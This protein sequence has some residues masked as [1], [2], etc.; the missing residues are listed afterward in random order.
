MKD[1]KLLRHHPMVVA[2]IIFYQR[3]EH[4]KHEDCNKCGFPH[5]GHML[6]GGGATFGELK[7]GKDSYY[8]D[9]SNV[10]YFI[11]FR[12]QI[13]ADGAFHWRD[14]TFFSRTA[15][16]KVKVTFYTR[17]NNSPQK[18]AWN[19]PDAEWKSIVE[20]LGNNSKQS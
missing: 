14:D 13:A 16:G 8:V 5:N 4:Q 11:W 18:Q 12:E 20:S 2:W 6:C 15:D 17:F 19:I 9:A 10:E 7:I 1:L 3:K